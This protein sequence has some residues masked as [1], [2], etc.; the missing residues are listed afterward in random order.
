MYERSV[1]QPEEFWAEVARDFFW[2]QPW[3]KVLDYNFDMT[4]GPVSCRWFEGAKTNLCY[5]AVDRHLASAGERVAFYFEG[6][7]TFDAEVLTFRDV[8]RRVCRVA[9][10]LKQYGVQKGDRVAIYMP[11]IP[12][13]PIAMLACARIGAIHSVIFGGFSADSVRDRVNDSDCRVLITA[14]GTMRGSKHVPLKATIDQALAQCP[15]VRTVL[16]W[17]RLARPGHMAHVNSVPVHG[18]KE[19]RDVDLA[20]AAAC[21]SD[22]CPVEWMDAEDP[23][24]LLYTSGST[25]KPKAV[26]HTTGGYM[27][28]TATTFKVAFDFHA[29]RGDV[30]FCTADCGWITGHSYVAYGPMCCGATQVVFEG[31][32]THPGP[33]RLWQIINKC[34]VTH[35]Y[36]APT[37][38]RALM[39]LG[40]SHPSKVDMSCL[41][42]LGSVGEPINPAA[43]EW[44]H[45]VVGRGRC[46]IVD[47]FWQ[48]ETGS[49]VL[50]PIAFVTPLKP[51]SAT[52]PFF[53]HVPVILDEK[54]QE[55]HGNQG[56]TIS[57][58]LCLKAP[59]PS[60][61][62][63]IWGDHGRFE[64]TYF[65]MFKGYYLTGDGCHRDGDGYYFIDGRIDDVMNVSG[66]RVGTAEVESALITHAA[67]AEAAV[68]PIN[69][70]LK[71]Q[72]IY[73]YVT[74]KDGF[75]M[76]DSLRTEL[77]N[78]VRHHIGAIATPDCIHDASCGLPKTRSGKIMRRI[79]RKI[80]N[81]E[82]DSGLGDTTTLADPSVVEQLLH[83]RSTAK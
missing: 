55:V 9:N 37:A 61:M 64:R 75:S 76:S 30:F 78:S 35:F 51:G 7:D 13:L 22:D 60:M 81:R 39:R 29:E 20:L 77:K 34:R 72:G 69:H 62:R 53:G 38:I 6:N 83:N 52:M 63:T 59:W 5:N 43:W 79:L 50:T 21:V 48:T 4:K 12:E 23:L 16:C 33:D 41:K 67:V 19:G 71:G 2:K 45:R 15:S 65:E 25:G 32:P 56:E 73:C 26:V 58:Y 24:F 68:V 27:V 74:L 18:W 17:P 3:T 70:E 82:E 57:G 31:I 14:D 36:T 49:F 80:A 42:V 44:F 8:H 66:H 10:V 28:G 1:Q 46:P 54:G 11:M 40:E 47:T